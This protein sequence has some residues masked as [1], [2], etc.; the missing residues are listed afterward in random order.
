MVVNK[1]T[2]FF[3]YSPTPHSR[4]EQT[5]VWRQAYTAFT[6]WE[7]LM[8]FRSSILKG[9]TLKL[10]YIT[11][12]R[13][14]IPICTAPPMSIAILWANIVSTGPCVQPAI[15]YVSLPVISLYVTLSRCTAAS[16]Q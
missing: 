8:T 16:R 10:W 14:M 9:F 7:Y 13:L 5:F 11:H 4:N 12:L 1:L 2:S 3:E 6:V 15:W